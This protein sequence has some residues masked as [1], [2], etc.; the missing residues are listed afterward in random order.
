MELLYEAIALAWAGGIAMH[1]SG[2]IFRRFLPGHISH[3]MRVQLT[4]FLA[5]T[6]HRYSLKFMVFTRIRSAHCVQLATAT[7]SAN[8]THFLP[9]RKHVLVMFGSKMMQ[10]IPRYQHVINTSDILGLSVEFHARVAPC[11]YAFDL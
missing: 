8:V 2:A 5:S 4:Q 11:G 3:T 1:R 10:T 6:Y 7:T 9:L